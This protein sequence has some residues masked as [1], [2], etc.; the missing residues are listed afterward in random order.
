MMRAAVTIKNDGQARLRSVSLFLVATLATVSMWF[1][2]NRILVGYQEADAAANQRP[3]GNLSDL[4]PR[5]LGAR[6]LLLHRS[7]PYSAAITAEIQKGYYGRVLDP[8]RPGD[9]ADQQGFAYPVYVVFLLAPLIAIP[10]NT[11]HVFFYWLLVG[12]TAGSVCLWLLALDWRLP[13]LALGS[14]II[15]TLGC[16][17]AVQGIKLQQLTLLVAAFLAGAA[18]CVAAGWLFWGGVLLALATIKPQLAW[19]LVLWLLLWS[20]SNWRARRNLTIGFAAIM[21]PLLGAAEIILPGWWL[22]FAQA[23]GRYHGYTHNQSVLEDLIP[24]ALAA[25]MIALAAALAAA[26]ILWRL[27][28][29]PADASEFGTATALVMALTVLIVPMSAAY[30]QVLLLPPI[31]LL[32]RDRGFLLARSRGVRFVCVLAGVAIAWQWIAAAGLTLVYLTVS[33]KLAFG[34]WRWPLF[35]T[36]GIP[37]AVFAL[38][39]VAATE[40]DGDAAPGGGGLFLRQERI[41]QVNS[42]PEV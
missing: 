34:A 4:Y 31:L 37:V 7:N 32:V 39:L 33:S 12:V 18:A 41:I 8:A 17:A 27:R 19:P 40:R 20:L 36:V 14:T 3:R 5:W 22:M 24:W 16:F 21:L 42:L 6:E 25:N 30:N 15:L 35:S 10:F 9:P 38:T 23:V 1:Y 13:R 29:A 11:V 28:K 2:V 26:W